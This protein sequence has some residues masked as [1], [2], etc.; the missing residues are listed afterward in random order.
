MSSPY[1][2]EKQVAISAVVRACNLASLVFNKLVKGETLAKEDK[3]P[4]TSGRLS[5]GR[6][7]AMIS[8]HMTP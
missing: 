8:H 7:N 2:L 5:Y 4:V 6:K 1:Q 3:S